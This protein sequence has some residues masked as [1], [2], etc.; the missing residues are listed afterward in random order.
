MLDRHRMT[1]G[2]VDRQRLNTAYRRFLEIRANFY[3]RPAKRQGEMLARMSHLQQMHASLRPSF[4][5]RQS[6]HE[7]RPSSCD[8]RPQWRI[9]TAAILRWRP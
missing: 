1:R 7:K 9:K 6:R 8:G 5:G 3:Y 4:T 2:C